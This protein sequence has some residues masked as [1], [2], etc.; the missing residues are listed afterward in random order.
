MDYAFRYCCVYGDLEIIKYIISLKT[1]DK[2]DISN[3]NY[4]GFRNAYKNNH[5]K[6]IQLLIPLLTFGMF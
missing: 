5:I 3:W 1:R 4:Y 6:T 2:I